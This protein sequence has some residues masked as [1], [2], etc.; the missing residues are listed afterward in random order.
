MKSGAYDPV[1]L[2]IVF[3]LVH[4]SGAAETDSFRNAFGRL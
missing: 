4:I 3:T 1:S 2:D